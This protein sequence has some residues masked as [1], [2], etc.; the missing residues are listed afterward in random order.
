MRQWIYLASLLALV[1]SAG[2]ALA[3]D[4]QGV[5]P[6][7]KGSAKVKIAPCGA[8]LCSKIVWLRESKGKDGGPVKDQLNPNPRLQSR[9]VIG[10]VTFSGLKK[11]SDKK[12][13]GK[14]YNPEDGKTYLVQLNVV[15]DGVIHVNGCRAGTMECG[16]RVWKRVGR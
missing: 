5:W 10:L 11:Q 8:A 16:Q 2:V 13:S 9:P 12:W 3:D 7:H 4:P 15:Q 14:I 6:T 1:M